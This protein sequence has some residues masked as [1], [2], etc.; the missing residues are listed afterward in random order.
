MTLLEQWR[1]KAYG[2]ELDVKSREQLWTR[3]FGIEKGIYEKILKDPSKVYEGTVKSLAEEFGTDTEIMTGFLDG[4]NESL[5]GYENP[6]ETMD[7]ET[8]LKIEIDPSNP[9]HDFLTDMNKVT[10]N[11]AG[12]LVVG[13]VEVKYTDWT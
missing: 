6:L 10:M 7:E 2:D 1:T 11:T 9:N 8:Q 13:N 12:T 3:Y 4:I 5:K